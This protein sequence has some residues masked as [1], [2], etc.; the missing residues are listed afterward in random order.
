RNGKQLPTTTT[1]T[2]TTTAYCFPSKTIMMI[3]RKSITRQ[4][5]SEFCQKSVV[6]AAANN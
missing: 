2:I 5:L 3:S 4:A 6:A 1:K